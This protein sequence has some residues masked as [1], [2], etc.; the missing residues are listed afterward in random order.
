MR[1]MSQIWLKFPR[2]DMEHG[3]YYEGQAWSKES[4]VLGHVWWYVTG[5]SS[6]I[7]FNLS[8]CQSKPNVGSR[9]L[10]IWIMFR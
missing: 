4:K 6:H 5:F 7:Q 8:Q 2:F 3:K 10:Q 9:K 1:G